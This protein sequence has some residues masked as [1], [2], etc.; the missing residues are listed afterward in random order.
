MKSTTSK[1]LVLRDIDVLATMDDQ[2]T[3][4]RNAYVVVEDGWIIE[5]GS[6]TPPAA[7]PDVEVLPCGGLIATPGLINTHHHLFQTITRALPAAQN[8]RILEWMGFNYPYWRRIDEESVYA[9]ALV[10]LGELA[11]SGCSTSSDHLYAFPRTAGSS[12]ALLGAEIRAA[13]E[14]GMRFAP[15]RGAVDIS[16]EAGGSPPPEL[17]Q[18]TDDVLADMESAAAEFHDPTPGSM[19]QI[20]LAPNSM[21]ICSERLLLEAGDLARRL[22]L[23]RH[24]HVAEVLEE[25]E[26]S[27]QH[28]GVR[29]LRR[30]EELGWLGADVWLAH[31]VHVNSEEIAALAR[32]HTAV[33]HCPTSNM[34]LASGAAPIQEMLDT[35]VAVALGVDGSASNDSGNLL[36]EARQALLVSRLRERTRLMPA[37]TAIRLATR[38]GAA[39][40]GRP[41]LGQLAT[42]SQADIAL[43]PREGV[44]AAGTE[45][46][47]VAGL[48][49]AW[50]RP[51]R[52]LLVQG[53]LVVKDSALTGVD[54]QLAVALHDAALS[55]IVQGRS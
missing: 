22:G 18:D 36:G 26:Y 35:G 54:E 32:A 13:R 10:G 43:W 19:C 23:R 49:L 50:P 14:L 46:D 42:G 1:R 51:V 41:D 15:T 4:L 6:G 20:G 24:T 9:S 33:A 5:V 53:R 25:E 45:N 31:V 47:P 29:P 44:A 52:H 7:G 17:V 34:R 16:L 11:L 3:E 2:G 48:V 38:G 21:T 37:R 8:S 27:L 55:R 40:L 12:L 30:L 28:W 39:A